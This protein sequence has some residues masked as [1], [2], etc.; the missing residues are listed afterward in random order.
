MGRV[1]SC[2][3]NAAAENFFFIFVHKVLSRHTF[4][5][6]ADARKIDARLLPRIVTTPGDGAAA[7]RCAPQLRSK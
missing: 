3:D 7:Q 4:A 1:D 6:K 5:T 2:F